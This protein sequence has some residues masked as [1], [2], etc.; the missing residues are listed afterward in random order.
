MHQKNYLDRKFS[1]MITRVPT[2]IFP[3]SFYLHL[4]K[5]SAHQI[6]LTDCRRHH[7][8]IVKYTRCTLSKNELYTQRIKDMC[9]FSTFLYAYLAQMRL[10]S[11][12]IVILTEHRK[13]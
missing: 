11:D 9:I 8:C 6:K 5:D 3:Y 4:F 10:K 12:F 2:S 7:N 13:P 1:N